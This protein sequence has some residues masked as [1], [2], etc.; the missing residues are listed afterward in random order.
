MQPDTAHICTTLQELQVRRKFCIGLAN[1]QTNAAGALVRR[2]LGYD[3]K[4]E[5]AASE[6]VKKRAARIVG[7][8]INGKPQNEEDREI[9]EGNAD[10]FDMIA[11][12]LAPIEQRRAVIEK[13][14]K[15]AAKQLPAWKWVEGVRGF[16]ELGFAVLVGEAGDLSKYPHPRK[17]FKRLGLAPFEGKAYSRWR[18]EGGLSGEEWTAAGY[19]PSRRAEIHACIGEPLFRQQTIIT[20]PYRV[21]YDERRAKMEAQYPERKKAH[22]HNDALRIMTKALVSDL[23]AEWHG[24]GIR[25]QS[26]NLMAE[27]HSAQSSHA[28]LEAAQ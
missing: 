20:G 4:E 3:P 18:V 21:A 9:A 5:G 26:A 14:M 15:R 17:L 16:G 11:K 27:S 2:F 23:W 1:K 8:A 19:K 12:A 7:A 10:E 13:D 22:L 25:L 24:S 28:V 6:G